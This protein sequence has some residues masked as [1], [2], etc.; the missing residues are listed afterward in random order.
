MCYQHEQWAVQLLMTHLVYGPYAMRKLQS[1]R[2]WLLLV[3]AQHASHFPKMLKRP[4][5]PLLKGFRNKH[6]ALRCR[7]GPLQ[8]HT[9]QT[10]RCSKLLEGIRE[11]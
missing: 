2:V 6:V 3:A 10:S 4:L 5:F 8:L 9:K 7:F 1:A 11:A